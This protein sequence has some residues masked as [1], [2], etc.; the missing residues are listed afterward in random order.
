M[1]EKV[2]VLETNFQRIERLEWELGHLE[3]AADLGLLEGDD[4]FPL[5]PDESSE[6]ESTKKKAKRDNTTSGWYN[7]FQQLYF[8]CLFALLIGPLKD[9]ML[10]M[11]HEF[12]LVFINSLKYI[13]VGLVSI[14]LCL[15]HCRGW[16]LVTSRVIYLVPSQ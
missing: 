14:F 8:F 15:L 6:D 1:F 3:D 10:E 7:T 13:E 16:P 9:L 4:F 12:G 11:L 5:F 2:F